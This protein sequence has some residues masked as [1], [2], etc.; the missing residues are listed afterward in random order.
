MDLIVSQAIWWSPAL[1][2]VS[3]LSLARG[4][5]VE[6]TWL[7]GAVV[8]LFVYSAAVFWLPKV[9]G[10]PEIAGAQYNWTGKI[11]AI[12]T[13]LVMIAMLLK[14]ASPVTRET[15]GLTLRQR[16]GSLRP[17][18]IA[19]AVMIAFVVLLQTLGGDGN[20]PSTET[21]IYQATIPGLDEEPLFR[22]LLFALL[23]AA[24]AQWKRPALWAGIAVTI[25][26]TLGHSLFWSA[27]GT[28]FDPVA[29]VYVGVLGALLM[30]I[31]IRTGSL[32]IPVLAHNL[33]NV[34]SQLA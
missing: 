12:V 11:A 24:L 17:A 9:D 3:G 10:F 31:R 26:F 34:A 29:L 7:A 27:A 18:A 8:V 5:R 33:T 32:L 22:G 25:V 20:P 4:E 13:T 30:Y 19:T 28:S 2:L 23:L 14:S 1:L 15:L 21:L 16:E 6:W